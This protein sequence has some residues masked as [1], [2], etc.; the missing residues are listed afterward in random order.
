M[1]DFLEDIDI[2]H[3]EIIKGLKASRKANLLPAFAYDRVSDEKLTD[4]VSLEFQEYYAEEYARRKGL[5]IIHY[6]TKVESAFKKGR[7]VFNHM[8]NVAEQLG[9]KDMIFKNVDRMSRNYHDLERIRD[10]YE[11]K[12]FNIHLYQNN[13]CINKESTYDDKSILELE[14]WVAKRHSDKIS[15]D[16]R[17]TNKYLAEKGVAPARHNR[18]GYIYDKEKKQH[19]IDPTTKNM[20]YFIFD[21]FD[22]EKMALRELVEILNEKGYKTVTGRP[23]HTSALYSVLT[24]PFYAGKFIYHDKLHDGIHESYFSWE[25][26]LERKKKLN[27]KFQGERKRKGEFV[28]AKF[29]RYQDKIL[30]GEKKKSRYIYYTN[31]YINKSFKEEDILKQLDAAVQGIE[32]SK[33]FADDLKNMFKN[34]VEVKKRSQ[35][36]NKGAIRRKVSDLELKKDKYYD[37]FAEDKLNKSDLIRQIKRCDEEIKILEKDMQAIEVDKDKFLLTMADVIERIRRLP[38]NYKNSKGKDKVNLIREVA[39]SIDVRDNG[40]EINWDLPFA[41]ILNPEVMSFAD[42]PSEVRTFPA[43]LPR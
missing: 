20:M 26:F 12:E 27:S 34:S 6:F 30:T 25:R 1:E 7:K 29:L 38:A 32:Y 33:R 22:N 41:F 15:H 42:T 14:I 24:N 5:Y 40:I 16:V 18:I 11:N 37:L 8:L 9:V 23:W 21:I 19:L 2:N 10:L 13:R 4:G 28:F 43:R 17:T 39:T 36:A 35:S 31:R 3:S